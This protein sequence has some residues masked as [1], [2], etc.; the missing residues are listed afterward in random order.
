MYKVSFSVT[1]SVSRPPSPSLDLPLCTV[2]LSLSFCL[3][4]S[5]SLSTSLYLVLCPKILQSKITFRILSR[6]FR[7]LDRKLC[8]FLGA[9]SVSCSRQWVSCSPKYVLHSFFP[10]SDVILL[11]W[12]SLFLP[13]PFYFSFRGILFHSLSFFLTLRHLFISF[14][15]YIPFHSTSVQ[16][17][18]S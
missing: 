13:K 7:F 1:L 12:T 10:L 17:S 15:F 4:L 2:S 3:S 11:L 5:I 18:M 14:Y 16:F 9:D 8:V 6:S